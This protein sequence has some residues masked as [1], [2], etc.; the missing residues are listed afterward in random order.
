MNALILTTLLLPA[1][2]SDTEATPVVPAEAALEPPPD[3]DA[4]S[5]VQLFEIDAHTTGVYIPDHRAP[6]VDV[7]V[8][9]P[10]GQWDEGLI[11]A[12]ILEAWVDQTNDPEATLRTRADARAMR[13]AAGNKT[14][15]SI[16]YLGCLAEDLSEAKALL[17]DIFTN[18]TYDEAQFK[19]EAKSNEQGWE[20]DQKDPTTVRDRAVFELAFSETDPRQL[21]RTPYDLPVRDSEALA[22]LRDRM[23]KTPGRYV[24]FAGDLTLDQAQEFATGLLPAADP[25]LVWT[26]TPLEPLLER[27]ARHVVPLAN[28]NQAYLDYF[29]MGPTNRDPHYPAWLLAQHVL[30]GH[31][32][33][34]IS[35]ALRHEG[36]DT[37]SASSYANVDNSPRPAGIV[38][39]TRADNLEA[40]E[41]KVKDTLATFHAEGITAEELDEAV[42][43]F[44]GKALMR[45]QTPEQLLTSTMY[46]LGNDKPIDWHVQDPAPMEQLTL[47]EVNAVIREHFDPADFTMVVVVPE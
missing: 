32:Y 3:A 34:R 25:S 6:L 12:G 8:Q 37:Y 31:F 23:L 29:Q 24:A 36:G 44:R 9:V 10:V 28:T 35:V 46:N 20:L 18:R 27:P 1:L 39:F 2:A 5:A 26:E 11:D 33:S 14:G 19:R 15:R 41:Q 7:W 4:P 21:E 16:L 17:G 40:T 22:D 43:Y 30:G 45:T 13:L 47:D 38:T 42:R